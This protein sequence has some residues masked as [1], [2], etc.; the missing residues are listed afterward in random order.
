MYATLHRQ[1]GH[2]RN[3]AMANHMKKNQ[4]SV[5]S[6]TVRVVNGWSFRYS[7]PQMTVRCCVILAY[8]WP[9]KSKHILFKQFYLKEKKREAL[10]SHL[11]FPFVNIAVDAL[12]RRFDC[13]SRTA[14]W[15]SD[16]VRCDSL[17]LTQTVCTETRAVAPARAVLA[18][19]DGWTA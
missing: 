9:K 15:D 6:L 17:S 7:H 11:V 2:L 18:R 14:G 12:R 10:V 13:G 19:E 3:I 16:D 8:D 1:R 5:G 4:P